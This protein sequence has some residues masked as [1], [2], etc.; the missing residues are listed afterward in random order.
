MELNEVCVKMF[1]KILKKLSENF[2][3]KKFRIDFEEFVSF[4]KDSRKFHA[5]VGEILAVEK[6]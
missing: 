6:F 4:W 2:E 5:N 1:S 3:K